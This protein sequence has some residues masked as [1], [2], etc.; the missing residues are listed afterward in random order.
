MKTKLKKL[1]PV[2]ESNE[3][4]LETS[5]SNNEGHYNTDEDL[6]INST[7]VKRRKKMEK[8]IYFNNWNKKNNYCND[9]R[10]EKIRN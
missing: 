5:T 4:D 1:K 3:N 8:K 7:K 2:V 6:S 9:K 10:Y